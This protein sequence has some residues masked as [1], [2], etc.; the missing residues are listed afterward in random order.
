MKKNMGS[1]DRI[2]RV[3]LAIV[4][5]LLYFTNTVTGTLGLVLVILG[6]V[7]LLTALVR[8]CPLYAPFGI[9]TCKTK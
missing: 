4:F 3:I 2:I 8:F 7:F 5:A 9:S 6:G 1:T